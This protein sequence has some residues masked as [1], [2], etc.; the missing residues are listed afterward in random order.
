M[1]VMGSD[2]D[3]KYYWNA[4]NPDQVA[5]AREVFQTH[6]G[7][8]YLAFSMNAKGDQGEQMREFDQSANSILFI[9][10]MQGG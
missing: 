4:Q 5:I 8:G 6:R 1:S 7:R 9:P 2:G 10:A 3:T